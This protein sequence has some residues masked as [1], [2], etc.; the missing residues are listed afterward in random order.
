MF[1]YT[2]GVDTSDAIF[3]PTFP[4]QRD[5]RYSSFQNCE[6]V[7]DY[8]GIDA[9]DNEPEFTVELVYSPSIEGVQNFISDPLTSA[10]AADY[11]VKAVVPLFTS[12]SINVSYSS[13]GER[14]DEDV[15]AEEVAK[16]VNN[17]PMGQRFLSGAEIACAVTNIYPDTVVKLPVSIDSFMIDNEGTIRSKRS[18]NTLDIPDLPEQ[19]ITYL[20]ASF[21]VSPSDVN[22]SLTGDKK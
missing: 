20:T 6:V 11:V 15:I 21:M 22:V 9:G 13:T 16:A 1:S 10:P 4:E 12:I 3:T 2:F 18:N 8:V 17:V 5:G 19:G 14:P 7:F